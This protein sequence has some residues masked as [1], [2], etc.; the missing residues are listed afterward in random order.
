MPHQTVN[1]L[2]RYVGD[3]PLKGWCTD[4]RYNSEGA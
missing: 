2:L 3:A 1:E 4:G